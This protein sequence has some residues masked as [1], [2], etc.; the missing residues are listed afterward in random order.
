MPAEFV[1][2]HLRV[3]AGQEK[4]F[5]DRNGSEF[6]AIKLISRKQ[7]VNPG[8]LSWGEELAELNTLIESVKNAVV[9][10][11]KVSKT[12]F[13]KLYAERVRYSVGRSGKDVGGNAGFTAKTID[14][15]VKST[16]AYSVFSER[17]GHTRGK[18]RTAFI[19][20]RIPDSLTPREIRSLVGS[21]GLDGNLRSVDEIAEREG[22]V[23]GLQ[24]KDNAL[25]SLMRLIRDQ[26]ESAE[27]LALGDEQDE[28]NLQEL[29]ES[30]L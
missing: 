1:E 10:E 27:L 8:S 25:L 20:S 11:N 28:I 22:L 18:K 5:L 29:S 26:I 9:S 23:S 4:A 15:L 14:I 16:D 12:G 3:P 6:P 24:A 2:L 30:S 19:Y 13:G 7:E 17:P 21:F